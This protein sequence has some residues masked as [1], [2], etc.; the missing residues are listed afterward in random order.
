MTQPLSPIQ[1]EIP[2][3]PRSPMSWEIP[4]PLSPLEAPRPLSPERPFLFSLIE[5][6][7]ELRKQFDER[8]FEMDF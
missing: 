2:E 7:E 5:A 4:Q 1:L 8:E 3:V 6:T